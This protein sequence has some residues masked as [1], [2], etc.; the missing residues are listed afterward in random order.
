MPY[1]VAR[2]AGHFKK[3]GLNVELV[4]TRG[5][6]AA[7]QAL[8]GDAVD[9]AAT[10]ARRRHHRP[11]AKSAP[12]S[13]A[14]RSPA[15]CRCSRVVTA[16]K[17]ADQIKGIKAIWRAR[18]SRVSALGNADHALTLYLLK[19]AGADAGKVKFATMGVNLLEALRQGQI[20]AG[21]VQEPAL[22]LLQ[23]S[24]AR[25]LVNAMD[26]ERRQA[27]ISAARSNSWASRCA[28]RR[29]SSAGRRWL[30]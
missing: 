2:S 27:A 7:M 1:E 13:A 26:L 10:V 6:S 3:H 28:P 4:Y 17:T 14:S 24:G 22:T 19:Q 9:Y 12:T 20:D 16:P 29:S 5:G 15:G 21:L 8:V 25:V 30:R 23:R 11:I 18:R